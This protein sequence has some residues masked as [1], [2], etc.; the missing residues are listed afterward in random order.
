MLVSCSGGGGGNNGGGPTAPV[1]NSVGRID[2]TPLAPLALMSGSSATLTATAFTKDNRSLGSAGVTWTSSN[3]NVASVAGGVV[4]AKLVGTATI[5][6]TSGSVS[7]AGVTVT[8]SAGAAS[9]LSIRTQPDGASSAATMTTP[10]VVEVRDAAGNLVISSTVSITVALASGGGALSGATTVSAVGGVA[11]FA[12]LSIT[13]LIGARTLTFSASGLTSV[14]SASFTLAPG[15]ATQLVIRAQPVANTAYAVFPTPAVVEIRDAQ[16]N[17]ANSTASV[18]ATLASGGGAL[19]G[20]ATVAAVAG[21]ATFTSLTVQGTAGV[22]TLT[23]SSGTLAAVTSAGFSVAAAPPAVIAFGPIAANVTA[24]VGRDPANTVIAVTNSGVFPLTNL[25]VVNITYNP[26]SPTGWLSASW[27]SGTSAPTNLQLAI[28]SSPFPVGTYT[29]YVL[30]A[31]DGAAA[32]ATLTVTLTVAPALV[33]TYGTTANKISVVATGA[34]LS[35][36]LVTTTG[37]GVPTTTDATVTYSSRSPAIASVDATGKITAVATGQAWIVAGSTQANADSVQVIVP[38]GSGVIMRTDLTN[39][40][41]R[42]GDTVTVHVQ[43]DT[44]GATL[45]AATVTFSWPVYTGPN[46][47][48]N[49]LS[50]IDVNTSASPMSP[51]SAVDRTINIMRLTGASVA[52]ATGVVDLAV[53][54]FRVTRAGVFPLYINAIELIGTD[55]SNLLPTATFTQYPLSVP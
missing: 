14:T 46:G 12:G 48:Y 33:N 42:I 53:V 7:S 51:T 19:G 9:Q 37:A 39:Y 4:T 10:P 45:G 26:I 52:G 8:V 24:A 49:A 13:G 40:R 41:Y 22:R 3:D 28:T 47:D 27:P 23:F 2:V 44:R 29:A 31:G 11:T 25:R 50:F 1:D 21:V 34:T 16:G 35:P 55:L 6:A 17:V 20:T 15:V 32:S 18:T 43:A 54:R 38:R 5:T 36:G 30:V